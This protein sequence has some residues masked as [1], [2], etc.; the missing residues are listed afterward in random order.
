[1]QLDQSVCALEDGGD[2]EDFEYGD[3]EPRLSPGRALNV[4][5]LNFIID[6]DGFLI[7]GPVGHQLLSGGQSV[8]GAGHATIGVDGSVSRLDL[9]FSGHYRPPLSSD[10][11]RYVYRIFSTHPLLKLRPDCDYAG[12]KFES[13]DVRSRGFV[14][15]ESELKEREIRLRFSDRDFSDW[16]NPVLVATL[17]CR[18][19]QPGGRPQGLGRPGRGDG[20]P[21]TIR[22]AGAGP[23][24]SPPSDRRRR[25]ATIPTPMIEA[26]IA[27]NRPPSR[28]IRSPCPRGRS[29]INALLSGRNIPHVVACIAWR[30]P[31]K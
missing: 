29:A 24:G 10:Y 3:P 25:V 19:D 2:G 27:A 1:M 11:V 6:R 16:C 12:R 13:M 8:A 20:G 18:A 22:G 5:K 31:L 21:R 28:S 30:E 4:G 7:I 14:F 23:P 9:N 17:R 26:R 15:S